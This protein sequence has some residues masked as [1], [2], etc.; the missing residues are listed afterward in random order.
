MPNLTGDG[1]VEK[2]P[3]APPAA[4]VPGE[5]APLRVPASLEPWVARAPR[6]RHPLFADLRIN[7]LV[8]LLL[9]D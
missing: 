2:G 4:F 7:R 1:R 5:F 8:V 3:G 6:E 9:R